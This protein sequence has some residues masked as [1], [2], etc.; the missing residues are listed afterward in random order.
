M[1]VSEETSLLLTPSGMIEHRVDRVMY[2]GFDRRETRRLKVSRRQCGAADV[3]TFMKEENI[4]PVGC[5]FFLPHGSGVSYLIVEQPPQVRTVKWGYIVGDT[6]DD[7]RRRGCVSKY[8]LTE[9]DRDRSMFSLAF[10]YVVFVIH[11]TSSDIGNV[12]GFYRTEPLRTLDDPLMVMTTTNYRAS[13]GKLCLGDENIPRGCRSWAQGA[14]KILAHFW[15]SRFNDHWNEH[16]NDARNR[17][18][19]MRTIWEWEYWSRRTPLWPLA[20]PWKFST[21]SLRSFDGRGNRERTPRDLFLQLASQAR[22][23]TEWQNGAPPVAT[24]QGFKP[25][26]SLSVVVNNLVIRQGDVLTAPREY[27]PFSKGGTYRVAYFF[28]LN[29]NGSRYAKLEGIKDPV[30]LS[31]HLEKGFLVLSDEGNRT[32]KDFCVAEGIPLVAGMRFILTSE[33][34]IT[35]LLAGRTFQITEVHQDA[36]GDIA[37]KVRNHSHAVFITHSGGTLLPSIRFLIPMLEGTTF[38]YGEKTLSVGQIFKITDSLHLALQKGMAVRV[39]SLSKDETKHGCF[40]V[41]FDGLPGAFP[42]MAEGNFTFAW[43]DYCYECTPTKISFGDNIFDLT[44]GHH[45]LVNKPQ[46]GLAVGQCYVILAIVPSQRPDHHPLDLDLILQYGN[47][48]VPLIAQSKWQLLGGT[49]EM[50]TD[51]YTCGKITLRRGQILRYTGS[52]MNILPTN[53]EL[54]IL[55]FVQSAGNDLAEVVFTNGLSTFLC[56]ETIGQNYQVLEKGIPRRIENLPSGMRILSAMVRYQRNYFQEG[57][58]AI[59][60][61]GEGLRDNKQFTGQVCVVKS[62]L[63]G[64]YDRPTE[65]RV[66]FLSD[67]KQEDRRI[68]K[69]R[70]KRLTDMVRPRF[71]R[72]QGVPKKET[73]EEL[74]HPDA[75]RIFQE[76]PPQGRLEAGRDCRDRTVQIGDVVKPLRS[77]FGGGAG[78]C[79]LS[80]R[81]MRKN[82]LVVG[83]GKTGGSGSWFLYLLTKREYTSI[84]MN[85]NLFG[86]G[87]FRRVYEAPKYKDCIATNLTSDCELVDWK[88]PAPVTPRF[89][90]EQW[91]RVKQGVTPQYGWGN[92]RPNDAG[93]IVACLGKEAEVH[94]DNEPEWIG[95]VEELELIPVPGALV[96]LTTD[97]PTYLAGLVTT[98]MTGAIREAIPEDPDLFLVDFPSHLGFFARVEELVLI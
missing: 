16:Y 12:Y 21:I 69:E 13:D 26:A 52:A 25:V 65:L 50:A 51:T 66:V 33:E 39:S 72:L 67:P 76:G 91:V 17:I 88:P 15:Q 38:R 64:S 98:S 97:Q 94:F 95:L 44:F 28:E 82:F 34:D 58:F 8:E 11:L 85:S 1:T 47:A 59:L 81:G 73:E 20:A 61:D 41:S 23:A 24:D 54:T 53:T 80:D 22:S 10:P 7:L 18:P 86:Y 71:V 19:Q 14:E 78:C 68:A 4:F 87:E 31:Y 75:L 49:T 55:C 2:E 36:D 93:Q 6:W 74:N 62:E 45:L 40:L 96:R 3:V 43:Q 35:T 57:D 5:R 56:E 70:F 46:S 77:S 79:V 29:S 92:V 84:E 63:D 90:K 32:Q 89:R 60:T 27:E 83:R 30:C 37:V 9:K 48:P 42:I